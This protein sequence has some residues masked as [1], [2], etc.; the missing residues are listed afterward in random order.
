M[1]L[2]DWAVMCK[3]V[4][5]VL[6]GVGARLDK[7]PELLFELRGVNHEELIDADA[8]KAVATATRRGKSRRL[9]PAACPTS[10]GMRWIQGNRA[11]GKDKARKT[12]V[13]KSR[14]TKPAV[15]KKAV[16]KTRFKKTTNK[17]KAQNRR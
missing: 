6:Y 10:S 15:K 17:R 11:K 14:K 7:K 4:A 9:S 13:R 3:H 2:P 8:E 16:K 5:A 12:E 1:R